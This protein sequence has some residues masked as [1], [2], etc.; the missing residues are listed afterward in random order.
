MSDL[1]AVRVLPV[2]FKPSILKATTPMR[3]KPNEVTNPAE[4]ER[5]LTAATIGRMAT[6]GQD[7]Y[8]YVTPVNFVFDQGC[9]YFHCALKG[10]KLD[11][12]VRD[13]K[14]C[15]EVDIP[16]AYLDLDFNPAG[17]G[18]KVTQ[19]Y[20]SVIIR[21]EARL[22][23]DGERK[24][25]ALNAL[26]AK[27]EPGRSFTLVDAG[28]PAYKACA[29]VE[30]TPRSITGKSNLAQGKSREARLA[31]ARYLLQRRRAGDSETAAAMGFDP[32]Q[33]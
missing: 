23:P 18:C 19:F 1:R 6:I 7:G 2:R 25:A 28:M 21:G 14:V 16:L 15:F 13:P 24:V 5:I 22:L 11:N 32:D 27:H 29:V 20:H 12:I 10:E 26:V 30:I 4:L 8:P 17:G 3:R 9:V 33:I 31:I